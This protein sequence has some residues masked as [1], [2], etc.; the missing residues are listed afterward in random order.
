MEAA[1]LKLGT[2]IPETIPQRGLQPTGSVRAEHQP[3]Q[4]SLR[5]AGLLHDNW[6]HARK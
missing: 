4:L 5:A 6:P 2:V 1:K 3:Q